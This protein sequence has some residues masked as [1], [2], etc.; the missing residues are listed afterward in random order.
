[1]VKLLS[2]KKS[3]DEDEGED[4]DIDAITPTLRA[5]LVQVER[6]RKYMME[7]MVRRSSKSKD[8]Q[9]NPILGIEPYIT[10]RAWV[11]MSEK[12]WEVLETMSEDP[13][14]IAKMGSSKKEFSSSSFYL[15]Y[16][17]VLCHHQGL[18]VEVPSTLEEYR[19]NPS[20]K[21]DVLVFLLRHHLQRDDNGPVH[22]DE[23]GKITDDG[24][25][26]P[27]ARGQVA[28][29]ETKILLTR[30]VSLSQVLALHGIGVCSIDGK[31]PQAERTKI[32]QAFNALEAHVVDGLPCRVL[33]VSQV[34]STGLN[35]ARA[36][37][38]MLFVSSLADPC[39]GAVSRL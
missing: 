19:A 24:K 7:I 1:M 29:Q 8:F 10:S 36:N 20:S 28:A 32:L 13:L 31:T 34:G 22:F 23:D 12:E 21:L 37:I 15:S 33:V 18:S 4:E 27:L 30:D 26:P 11:A 5:E 35:I 17:I 25:A 16:R 14:R 9:G 39:C 3:G 6:L 38:V 2:R